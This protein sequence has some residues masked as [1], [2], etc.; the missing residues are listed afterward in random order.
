MVLWLKSNE[1]QNEKIIPAFFLFCIKFRERQGQEKD[2]SEETHATLTDAMDVTLNIPRD[3]DSFCKITI[4]GYIMS[5]PWDADIALFSDG[6]VKG[7]LTGMHDS[8]K[9]VLKRLWDIDSGC[10]IIQLVGDEF[11]IHNSVGEYY[12]VGNVEVRSFFASRCKPATTLTPIQCIYQIMQAV[13]H[14]RGHG[15]TAAI[16]A[17]DD[18]SFTIRSP[19]LNVLISLGEN[20]TTEQMRRRCVFWRVGAPHV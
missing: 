11:I 19:P 3:T 16:R 10:G 8:Y 14:I 7:I 2:E 17:M 6:K 1:T 18:G 13:K 5:V 4:E 15:G 9:S 12:E 20:L